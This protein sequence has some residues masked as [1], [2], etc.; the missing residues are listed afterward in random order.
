MPEIM[1]PGNEEME[2]KENRKLREWG[3]TEKNEE[4][5]SF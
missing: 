4:E 3:R 1:L 5:K 2:E